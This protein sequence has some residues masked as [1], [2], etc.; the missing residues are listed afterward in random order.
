MVGF[1]KEWEAVYR[2]G[3]QLSS[4][5]WTDVVSLVMRH[6]RPV[7]PGLRVLELGPGAGAN[8]P[9]LLSLGFDY[10]GIEGSPAA[11]GLLHEQFPKLRSQIV[12]GDFSKN[13]VFDSSF[14]LVLDR[15]SLTCNSTD[16]ISHTISCLKEIIVPNGKFIGID[17]YSTEHSSFSL[18]SGVIDSFTKTNMN[19]GQF[20]GLGAIHFSTEAH[21]KELF[22]GFNF[23][24]LEH[25][26]KIQL[27][28][29]H[30]ETRAAFN[31][32]V[33]K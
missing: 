11:V 16:S 9:F 2:A 4:W 24:S 26:K 8:I 1:S 32:V 22:A 3:A 10:Y 25:V 7:R 28:G 18:D 23:L 6:A 19:S 29:S 14:D 17:W 31:F 15:A 12:Q 27:I 20:V 13:L 33:E 30:S 21:L 5:P